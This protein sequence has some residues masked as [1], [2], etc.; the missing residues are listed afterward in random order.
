MLET[1]KN[2]FLNVLVRAIIGYVFLTM[3]ALVIFVGYVL[4][5]DWATMVNFAIDL[6][7][8]DFAKVVVW[9]PLVA[10]L[11]KANN[12]TGGK[13]EAN[14]YYKRTEK[15]FEMYDTTGGKW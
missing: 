15:F 8:N 6:T 3:T 12:T 7:N 2:Y 9:L 5:T 4:I 14:K 10:S 1:I 11:G 13:N